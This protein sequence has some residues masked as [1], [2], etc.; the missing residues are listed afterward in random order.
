M[1]AFI[2][3]HD[4]I[5]AMLRAGLRHVRRQTPVSWRY[6]N[7]SEV[8]KLGFDT[9]DRVGQMLLDT[10]VEGVSHR[11]PNDTITSLPGPSGAEWL[12]PYEYRNGKVPTPTQ[13][14][15][16]LQCYMY[17]T[18]EHHDWENT[19][20]WRFCQ[21]YRNAMIAALPGYEEAPWKWTDEAA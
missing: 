10:N 5:H 7:P 8:E 9:V 14:L 17:Q 1:S 21:A 19:E 15:K 16:L 12:I 6:G 4:H 20:A 11:Y 2:V 18:M 3:G 13:A